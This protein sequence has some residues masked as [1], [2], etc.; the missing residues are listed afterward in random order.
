MPRL[1][2]PLLM[3]SHLI[4]L[5]ILWRHT[6]ST[7][8]CL[9]VRA[10]LDVLPEIAD[11]AA[12]LFVGFEAERDDRDEAEGE[13]FPALHRTRGEVAAVLA[14]EGEVFGAFEL[15]GECCGG[16]SRGDNCMSK[17]EC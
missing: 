13:P 7:N 16:I 14:L 8:L 9:Y 4:T 5:L 15:R 17:Q 2:S 10:V 11:M 6:S 1:P 3:T 12:E